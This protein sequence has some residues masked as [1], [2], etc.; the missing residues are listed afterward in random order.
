[1]ALDASKGT[2][3]GEIVDSAGNEGWCIKG[4]HGDFESRPVHGGVGCVY[5]YARIQGPLLGADI[6]PQILLT[7]YSFSCKFNPSQS[8]FFSLKEEPAM[9]KENMGISGSSKTGKIDTAD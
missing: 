5:H 6:V 2:V 1:M 3:E 7:G 9:T 8:E 4:N